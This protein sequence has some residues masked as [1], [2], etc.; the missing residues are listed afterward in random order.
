MSYAIWNKLGS[1][2]QQSGHHQEAISAYHKA[3][4]LHPNYPRVWVNLGVTYDNIKDYS[5]SAQYF[6]SAISLNPN[7]QHIWSY[8]KASFS[9]SGQEE[10]KELCKNKNLND[11]KGKFY[12][13][14]KEQLPP[15][16]KKLVN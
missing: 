12:I 3:L 4:D 10:L 8:L 14:T 11:F 16:N 9:A 13:V 1:A 15:P 2:L 7:A 5:K 6:L